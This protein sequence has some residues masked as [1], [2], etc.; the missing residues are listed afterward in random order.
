MKTA[1]AFLLGFVLACGGTAEPSPAP[2]PHCVAGDQKACSCPD[3][4]QS[5]QQCQS[6][7]T[8]APCQCTGQ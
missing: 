2:P 7:G 6:D 1:A 5:V 8:W 4:T 3:G